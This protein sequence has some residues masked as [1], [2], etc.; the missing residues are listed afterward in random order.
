[1]WIGEEESE[2]SNREITTHAS[3]AL[4]LQ[5]IRMKYFRGSYAYS[6]E[7]V[8]VSLLIGRSVGHILELEYTRELNLPTDNKLMIKLSDV[9]D[10][11]FGVT[12]PRRLFP[13]NPIKICHAHFSIFAYKVIERF[14]TS[15]QG[16]AITCHRNSYSV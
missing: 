15:I 7:N 8:I 11:V 6:I 10:S 12:P 3:K 1:M 2:F 5:S 16:S 9:T 14:T 4:Y 13:R